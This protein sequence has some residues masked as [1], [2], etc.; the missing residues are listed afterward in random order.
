MNL[1]FQELTKKLNIAYSHFGYAE[2]DKDIEAAIF[3]INEAEAK[4]DSYIKRKR[5]DNN[6]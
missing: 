4:I 2:N 3:E 1:S 6:G 5:T